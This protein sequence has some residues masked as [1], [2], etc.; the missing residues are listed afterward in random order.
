[1]KKLVF[2]LVIAITIFSLVSCGNLWGNN[3]ENEDVITVED[4]YLVVN[5]VKTEY[6]VETE[7][8]ITVED[9]YLVVNG[10]KTEYKVNECEHIWETVTTSPTCTDVGY[11]TI[12]CKLCGESIKANETDP[13]EHTYGENYV[14]DDNYHWF[15]CIRCDAAK[16]K[17]LHTL[18]ESGVC[19]VCQLPITETPG[20]IYAKAA[21]GTY[22]EVIGY[23]G[24]ATKVK[25]AKEYDGLP[26]KNICR[27]AFSGKGIIKSVVIPDS[28]TDIGE[29]AFYRCSS[30][31]SVVIGNNVTNI[32]SSAFSY[33]DSLT[34]VFIPN[35]VTDISPNSF[36]DCA[37]LTEIIVA[38]NNKHYES[39][40]GNLYTKGGEM[41]VQYAAGKNN[42]EFT[43]PSCV[44]SIG[45]FA[46]YR[47]NSLTSV[48]IGDSVTYIYPNAFYD[49]N[50]LTSVIIGDSVTL[51]DQMAFY[52]C[53]SL[54]FNE[55]SNCKYLGNESNPYF[56]L[57]EASN[58]DMSNYEIHEDTKI[59]AA[60]AFSECS[61]LASII[62]PDG[63]TNISYDVFNGCSSL[64][65]VVIPDSVTSISGSAF[66]S[67]T[68]LTSVVIPDSVTSIGR[69]AFYGCTSLTSIVIPDSVTSISWMA[70]YG[71]TSLAS[72][73][74]PDSVTN[75]DD[76]AFFGC[77][78]LTD[79]YYTGTEE[80]WAKI[81]IEDNNSDL[82]NANIHY[83]YT[84]EG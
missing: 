41:M 56:A 23:D 39:L 67:C 32:A 55:Y 26:V 18:D 73:V 20:V 17:E 25:I 13:I 84:P 79:V 65:S 53:D 80:E 62:I 2:A 7:D 36:I 1:M 34:S 6:K 77:D 82:T 64:T 4:G 60:Y 71:C 50:S 75:I 61:H 54:K 9:G 83:N 19:T 45:F 29:F 44:T 59:I 24:T 63:V 70:F 81:S 57:I 28:V 51:I 35:S 30:L 31:T 10:V 22:A 40:D 37:S 48:V 66:E 12:T 58:K 16:D 76:D 42:N 49:C 52:G 3:H 38:G 78:S 33:C 69:G 72:V 74:I 43:V 21:D 15:R 46:F 27:S 8:V 5:G 14:I 47:C 11:D 68:S